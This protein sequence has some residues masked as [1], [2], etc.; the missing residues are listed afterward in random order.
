LNEP[1]VKMSKR[2]DGKYAG[3]P[4]GELLGEQRGESFASSPSA[5]RLS[6]IIA[7][8]PPA[9]VGVVGKEA[10]RTAGGRL[11]APAAAR[12][13]ALC[14]APAAPATTHSCERELS[15]GVA[16]AAGMK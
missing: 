8:A 4:L 13:T 6:S 5:A 3:L 15:G 7:F 11:S 2:S 12:G 14:A 1:D 9:A 16:G 10:V